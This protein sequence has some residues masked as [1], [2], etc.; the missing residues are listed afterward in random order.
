MFVFPYQVEYITGALKTC[1]CFYNIFDAIIWHMFIWSIC[2][3]SNFSLSQL[4][5]YLKT[6]AFFTGAPGERTD[7]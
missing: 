6:H 7:L 3:M 4:M 2:C 1:I 5:Q